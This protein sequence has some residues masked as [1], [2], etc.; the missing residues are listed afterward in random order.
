[1]E[2]EMKEVFLALKPEDDM[3]GPFGQCEPG[4]CNARWINDASW[5]SRFITAGWSVYRVNGFQ[6]VTEVVVELKMEKK[7]GCNE[8]TES[9]NECGR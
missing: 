4:M 6:R 1:M 5:V 7:D 3:L 2:F 9:S 8:T